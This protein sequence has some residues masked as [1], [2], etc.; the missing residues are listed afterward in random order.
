VTPLEFH[1]VGYACENI[2]NELAHLQTLGYKLEGDMFA[3]PLQK[4]HGCFLSLG[5]NRIEL[6]EPTSDDSPLW[7][8][9]NKA[10]KMYH[11]AYVSPNFEKTLEELADNVAFQV[12]PPR[13]AV[14]FGGRRIS[15]LML[16][17]LLLVE[18]I[19]T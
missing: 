8:Y 15:F 11:L 10:I 14:A 5:S 12:T 4:V 3:D 2:H 17:S 16:R 1:H 13:A 19:E 6:L 9:L 7:L 18:I